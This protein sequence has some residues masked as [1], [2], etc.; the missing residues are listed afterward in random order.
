MEFD[1]SRRWARVNGVLCWLIAAS[2]WGVQLVVVLRPQAEIIRL[3]FP[4]WPVD[5][6]YLAYL[7][8]HGE[9]LSPAT[10]V[11]EKRALLPLVLTTGFLDGLNPCAFAVL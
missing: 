9:H 2:V 7:E 3:A 10:L 6:E 8:E 11:E 1:G 5:L 4:D